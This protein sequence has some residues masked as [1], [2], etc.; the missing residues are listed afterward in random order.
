MI[1]SQRIR[2]EEKSQRSVTVSYERRGMHWLC[3]NS[4]DAL[5]VPNERQCFVADGQG[6]SEKLSAA[7]HEMP[8]LSQSITVCECYSILIFSSINTSF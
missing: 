7:L 3:I 1:C 6:T 5:F 4:K 8:S 2:V